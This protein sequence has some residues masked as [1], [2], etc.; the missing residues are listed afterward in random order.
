MAVSRIV[1]EAIDAHSWVAGTRTIF[2]FIRPLNWNS[3]FL[4]VVYSNTEELVWRSQ[5]LC[6]R[7][8]THTRGWRG[9]GRSLRIMMNACE[10]VT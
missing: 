10:R 4:D 7:L 6:S 2:V 9:P 3:S 5:G 8:L 1:F